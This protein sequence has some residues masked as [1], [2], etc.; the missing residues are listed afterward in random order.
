MDQHGS[1]G[2]Q[3]PGYRAPGNDRIALQLPRRR[4]HERRRGRRQEEAFNARRR[5]AVPICQ[6]APCWRKLRA[7]A[8]G[9]PLR[10]AV[11]V[12]RGAAP[13]L[14]LINKLAGF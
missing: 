13:S 1:G 12:D 14:A 8:A 3:D 4:Q 7:A 11:I 2:C 9:Q 5:R 6:C 10:P